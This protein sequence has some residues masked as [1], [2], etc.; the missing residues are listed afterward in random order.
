MATQYRVG[1]KVVYIRDKYSSQPGPRAKNIFADRKGEHYQYQ[2]EKFWVVSRVLDDNLVQVQTR[3]GKLHVVEARDLRLRHA[4]LLEKLFKSRRFP[5]C[6]R[7]A[8]PANRQNAV[9]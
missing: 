4:T 5:S 2:V 8:Q 7:P 3:R 1:D 9:G 6:L